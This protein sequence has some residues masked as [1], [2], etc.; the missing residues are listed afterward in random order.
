ML[1]GSVEV[2]TKNILF[3][4]NE[5]QIILG[6]PRGSKM[7]LALN[8]LNQGAL[9]SHSNATSEHASQVERNI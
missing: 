8:E 3:W 7:S 2:W 9:H 5:G 4:F 6:M 1:E